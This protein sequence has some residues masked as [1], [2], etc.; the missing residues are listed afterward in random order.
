MDPTQVFVGASINS[1]TPLVYSFPAA[2]AANAN[3]T[4]VKQYGPYTTAAGVAI[5]GRTLG[6]ELAGSALWFAA[7]NRSGTACAALKVDKAT[8][9]LLAYV[10]LFPLSPGSCYANDVTV[11]DMGNAYFTDTIGARVYKVDGETFAASVFSQDPALLC[12][13][14]VDA[15]NLLNGCG[16]AAGFPGPNGIDYAGGY[17]VVSIRPRGYVYL[18][19]TA[20][21]DR[22]LVAISAPPGGLEAVQ[23][24]STDGFH[25]L[26]DGRNAL[27]AAAGNIVYELR[28]AANYKS[29]TAERVFYNTAATQQTTVVTFGEDNFLVVDAGGFV[30]GPKKIWI[31]KGLLA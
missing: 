10:D 21:A 5:D 1:T 29:A 31:G 14:G 12:A 17:L 2:A 30:M 3:V 9:A 18:S 23:G 27:A 20:P 25:F 8:A 19:T 28:F 22:G 26:P 24:Y 13:G 11:D 16:P 7:S 15:T 6:L 4:D